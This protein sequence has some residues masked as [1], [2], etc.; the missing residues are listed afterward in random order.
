MLH[1]GDLCGEGFTTCLGEADLLVY[2]AVGQE[3]V[4]QAEGRQVGVGEDADGVAG[5][6]SS[7]REA[8]DL[9]V[10]VAVGAVT[11]MRPAAAAVR[12]AGWEKSRCRAASAAAGS[13]PLGSR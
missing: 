5:L 4:G 6:A 10:S 3:C 11:E 13:V 7:T 12:M 2:E 1:Q 8:D 9:G